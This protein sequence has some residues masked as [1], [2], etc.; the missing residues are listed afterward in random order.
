MQWCVPVD[1][2]GMRQDVKVSLQQ[3]THNLMVAK[4]CTEMQRHM[5]FIILSIYYR[6]EK[7]HRPEDPGAFLF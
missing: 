7:Q 3:E 1:V 5:I 6:Q 2:D 4:S